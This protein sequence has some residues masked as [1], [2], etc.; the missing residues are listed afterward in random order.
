MDVNIIFGI[1]LI[2]TG[3]FSAGSFAVPFGKI[4]GWQWKTS[5]ML[6]S[7]WSFFCYSRKG[8]PDNTSS[9]NFCCS[10]GGFSNPCNKKRYPAGPGT[11]PAA[12]FWYPARQERF[13][14][15]AG[16]LPMGQ[17]SSLHGRK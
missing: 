13:R 9:R 10:V 15:P 2:A 16:R 14:E 7:S 17:D 3:A 12:V 5:W 8:Q 4:K 1:L 11:H 6:Y